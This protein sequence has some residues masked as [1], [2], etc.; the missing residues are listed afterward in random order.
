[1]DRSTVTNLIAIIFSVLASTAGQT[2]LKLGLNKVTEDGVSGA[3]PTL[4]AAAR[5]PLIY[6][7]LTLF[8]G[9]VLLWM[10]VLS[11]VELSWGYPLLGL[12]Y[13]T[14]TLVGVFVFNEHLS[15]QRLV[16]TAIVLLGALLVGRS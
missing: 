1:M 11:R 15:L 10:I 12:S 13:V 5:Q 7:G 8:V 14:V 9:S 6:G 3:M 4:L 16:G 2:L